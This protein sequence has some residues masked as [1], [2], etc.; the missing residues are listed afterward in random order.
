[1]DWFLVNG[2]DDKL[3]IPVIQGLCYKISTKILLVTTE[4]CRLLE[5]LI[6]CLSEPYIQE[7]SFHLNLNSTIMLIANLP[8]LDSAYY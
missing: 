5:L 6:F 1:M 3:H 4:T 7:E 2:S 8:N